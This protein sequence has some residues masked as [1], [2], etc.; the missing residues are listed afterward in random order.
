MSLEH[1]DQLALGT[2]ARP[3]ALE[4]TSA[5]PA[6]PQPLR[7]DQPGAHTTRLC[8]NI[9]PTRCESSHTSVSTDTGHL[10]PHANPL[11]GSTLPQGAKHCV[12]GLPISLLC[13]SPQIAAHT[14]QIFV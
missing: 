13:C 6:R 7:S 4:G 12:V 14:V 5:R 2:S 3:A 1:T 10:R 11:R 9:V 8:T